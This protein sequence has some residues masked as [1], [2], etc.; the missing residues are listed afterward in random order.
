MKSYIISHL[1]DNMLK[2]LYVVDFQLF[3]DPF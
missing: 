3:L 2:L 1:S